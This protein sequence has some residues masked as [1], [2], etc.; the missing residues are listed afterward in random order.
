[1]DDR[2]PSLA[3]PRALELLCFA[4][5]AHTLEKT[6]R[7]HL[8]EIFHLDA[9]PEVSTLK[10]RCRRSHKGTAYSIMFN[11]EWRS[12]RNA[13]R[14]NLKTKINK[15]ADYE[16]HLSNLITWIEYRASFIENNDFKN[17]FGAL[18][19]EISTDFSKI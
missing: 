5:E 18:F 11:S 4:E 19:T 2:C 9:L 12:A 16:T 15:A 8:A 13:F 6:Q 14:E 3:Q 1:M 7:S 17:T 10:A